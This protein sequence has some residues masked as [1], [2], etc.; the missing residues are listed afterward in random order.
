MR[1]IT[2]ASFQGFFSSS[3]DF[4]CPLID[5]LVGWECTVS[6]AEIERIFEQNLKYVND[7]NQIWAEEWCRQAFECLENKNYIAIIDK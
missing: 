4:I 1:V 5:V 7:K 6:K 3:Y 2:F